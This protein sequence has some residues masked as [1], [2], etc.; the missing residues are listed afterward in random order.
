M[1]IGCLTVS[2]SYAAGDPPPFGYC[3]W[4]EWAKAQDKAGFR[5]SYCWPCKK[6]MFPQEKCPH[7]TD[8]RMSKRQFDATER[9]ASVLANMMQTNA[10]RKRLGMKPKE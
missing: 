2:G 9:G 1:N 3:E 5:Q 7:G 8:R 6:W 4:H 10:G